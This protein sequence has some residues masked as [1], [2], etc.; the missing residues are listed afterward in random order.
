MSDYFA[1]IE[2]FL[3]YEPTHGFFVSFTIKMLY[4]S[5]SLLV[6]SYEYSFQKNLKTIKKHSFTHFEWSVIYVRGSWAKKL[7]TSKRLWAYP[8]IWIT[9]ELHAVVHILFH[10][11]DKYLTECGCSQF[12]FRS[13]K[14]FRQKF[15]LPMSKYTFI[16]R[17]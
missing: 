12:L 3:S 1:L 8:S 15:D 10:Q 2:T 16:V 4:S 7:L 6:Q 17:K 9:F 5:I 14:S 11:I 13:D